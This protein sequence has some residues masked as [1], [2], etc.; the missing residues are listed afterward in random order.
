M[1]GMQ[2]LSP[3][4]TVE[5]KVPK[6]HTATHC[7]LDR[8]VFPVQRKQAAGPGPEQEAQLRLQARQRPPAE[9]MPSMQLDTQLPSKLR[10]R[11]LMQEMQLLADDEL[12][13][14]QVW[15]HGVHCGL[16][17]AVQLPCRNSF[18]RQSVQ[19]V[20]LLQVLSETDVMGREMNWSGSHSVPV[21]QTVKPG[22]EVSGGDTH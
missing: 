4:C 21:L 16:D 10:L 15:W 6:G 18:K 14:A 2:R 11:P 7:A 1:H 19:L 3:G 5:L 9:Y 22:V 17:V 20:Q 8:Y 13:A 12:Q